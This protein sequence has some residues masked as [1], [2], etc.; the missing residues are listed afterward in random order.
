MLN[1]VRLN[2]NHARV[3]MWLT[4]N[5]RFADLNATLLPIM[6]GINF[7]VYH[8]TLGNGLINQLS[9]ASHALLIV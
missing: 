8:A 9:Y 5:K 7:N 3:V 1:Q 6:I 4:C 2:A